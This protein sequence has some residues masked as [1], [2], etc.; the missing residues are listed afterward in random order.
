MAVIECTIKPVTCR[1]LNCSEP[2]RGALLPAA[3]WALVAGLIAIYLVLFA[4]GVQD[5]LTRPLEELTYGESWL[6]DGA[7]QVARGERLYAAPDRLPLMQIAYTPV[8]YVV[9]G[10]LQR[11]VGDHGYTVGRAV[12]LV[13]TL[14]GTLALTWSVRCVTGFWR[15]GWLAG[16]LLL[17]QNL[18]VLLWGALERVDAL[19]LGL[20]LVGLALYTG[21]HTSAA[22]IFFVLAFFTKQ[23]YF[24]APIAAAIALWP[25][26]ASLLRFSV[27]MVCGVLGGVGLA[28]WLTDGWFWWHVV[29]ANANPLDLMTFSVLMGS[30][31]QF[32]GVPLLAALT[33]L[34]LPA[35]PGERVW[36]LYFVGCLLT[37]PSVAKLG[38]SSNYWVELT[39]ATAALLA[40]ASYRL[41]AWPQTRLVAPTVIAGALLIAVPGYQATATELALTR[42][43]TLQPPS[44]RYLSLVGDA[45]ATPLRIDATFVD[46]VAQQPG[47]VLTDN[48]GLAVAAGKPIEFEFQIFQLLRAEGHWSEQPIVDAIATR[49]FSLVVL[50]HPLDGSIGDTRWSSALQSALL[51]AYAP[52]G[53]QAGFWLYRPRE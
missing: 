27:L 10:G 51:D 47:D 31:L 33:S 18:T 39:A 13:S 14:I 19:A 3:I 34:V 24:V 29:T 12:S 36:R 53:S 20:T 25:C 49:R 2:R 44:P 11:V 42:A 7:R 50:M 21:R 26:R 37:L 1:V 38:A 8:Y 5:R 32:N 23:T 22:A 17:T 46:Y 52:A 48:S 43:D 40:L 45:G 30:F 41:A 35:G 4:L 15:F 28:L 16:G 9:V 6:L